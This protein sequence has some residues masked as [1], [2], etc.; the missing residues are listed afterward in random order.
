M[1]AGD[2]TVD[3]TV[4]DAGDSA[5]AVAPAP[6]PTGATPWVGPAGTPETALAGTSGT[7][8]ESM[9]ESMKSSVGGKLVSGA[10]SSTR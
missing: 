6:S 2:E 1:D 8:G 10:C 4:D 7:S 9:R 5:D 3:E